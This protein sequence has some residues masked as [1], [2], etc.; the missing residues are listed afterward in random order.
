MATWLTHDSRT[1]FARSST[2]PSCPSTC[3]TWPTAAL[4]IEQAPGQWNAAEGLD[5][6]GFAKREETE[7]LLIAD[8]RQHSGS[9]DAEL[10]LVS[11]L[12]LS[13]GHRVLI[14]GAC[15]GYSE[16][17][18]AHMVGPE[19][20]VLVVDS[21]PGRLE[22]CRNAVKGSGVESRLRFQ[23]GDPSNGYPGLFDRI[24]VAANVPRVPRPLVA[25]LK[26]DGLMVVPIVHKNDEIM[27]LLRLED[28]V[29][30]FVF[31]RLGIGFG[32]LEG[33]HAWGSV[34]LLTTLESLRAGTRQ[35]LRARSRINRSWQSL[36]NADLLPSDIDL[37]QAI[38]TLLE[39][40]HDDESFRGFSIALQSVGAERLQDLLPPP[41]TERGKTDYDRVLRGLGLEP[42]PKFLQAIEKIAGGLGPARR[43]RNFMAHPSDKA[44]LDDTKKLFRRLLGV[45]L[46]STP[47][48][49][50]RLQRVLLDQVAAV[51]EDLA[52]LL[53]TIT[54]D[55]EGLG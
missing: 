19:G 10:E 50:G 13:Q 11:L 34:E 18:V 40:A 5:G 9:A 42:P 22:L 15:Y 7:N 55:Q 45:P 24:F 12:E 20:E 17:L 8:A 23:L 29:P 53:Q 1:P 35:L 30:S 25:L 2:K 3:A 31:K 43:V 41:Q 39:P 52:D 51:F 16:T 54:R 49:Y 28:G 46:P 21:R 44:K 26:P 47:E 27:L 36:R 33:A 48:H 4:D 14:C 37:E 38:A 32:A 6:W